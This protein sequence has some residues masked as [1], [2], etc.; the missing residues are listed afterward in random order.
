MLSI[1]WAFTRWA[2]M[3][4]FLSVCSPVVTFM[5]CTCR[6]LQVAYLPF[7]RC[8]LPVCKLHI[9]E[10]LPGVLT[11]T[12]SCFILE[13]CH[14]RKVV[15]ITHINQYVYQYLYMG[16][17]RCTILLNNNSSYV[18]DCSIIISPAGG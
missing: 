10:S 18:N 11:S 7:S 5:R 13:L 6:Y 17:D 4:R 2:H 1:I 15:K 12:S 3:H 8:K 16:I 9:C 14:H